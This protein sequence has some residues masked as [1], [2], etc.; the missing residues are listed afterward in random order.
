LSRVRAVAAFLWS[1][2]VGD[3]WRTAVWLALALAATALLTHT[4]VAAWW[5]MPTAVTLVL[6]ASLRRM[7]AR[8]RR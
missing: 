6:V 3:D 4:G 7:T 8:N 2:V 5:L 1:F